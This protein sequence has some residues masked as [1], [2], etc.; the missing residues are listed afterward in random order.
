MTLHTILS[1][2]A[3]VILNVNYTTYRN[4]CKGQETYSVQ[5]IISMKNSKQQTQL[6]DLCIS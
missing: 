5:S 3:N 6:N 4:V 2:L 1:K